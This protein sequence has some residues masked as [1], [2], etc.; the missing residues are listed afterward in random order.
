MLGVSGRRRWR[1]SSDDDGTSAAGW[2]RVVLVESWAACA[3][4][5]AVA[6]LA[7]RLVL[8]S[9]ELQQRVVLA[10]HVLLVRAP[11]PALCRCDV[12]DTACVE[13]KQT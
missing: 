9:A 1:G 6:Q 7:S 12:E 8:L 5:V 13:D 3:S 2:R 10:Q 11:A 4:H